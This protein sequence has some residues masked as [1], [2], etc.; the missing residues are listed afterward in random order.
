MLFLLAIVFPPLAFLTIGKPFQ[1]M[2]SAALMIT[3][4]GWLPAALW[5]GMVVLDHRAKLN[6]RAVLA[7]LGQEQAAS[8]WGDLSPIGWTMAIIALSLPFAAAGGLLFYFA[9]PF[10]EEQSPPAEVP[11]PT[12]PVVTQAP[13]M[14]K[15]AIADKRASEPK[16]TTLIHDPRK[17]AYAI[18]AAARLATVAEI[19]LRFPSSTQGGNTGNYMDRRREALQSLRAARYAEIA[20]RH[21]VPEADID[22]ILAE[23]DRVGWPVGMVKVR[24]P[25]PSEIVRPD[26][27]A[28]SSAKEPTDGAPRRLP[29]DT[30]ARSLLDMATNH[31]R[32]GRY[33]QAMA[34]YREVIVKYPGTVEA[35]EAEDASTKVPPASTVP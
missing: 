24:T 35:I 27:F 17:T 28:E 15:A 4:F 20:R 29:S 12:T 11:A 23:G 21:D 34:I 30:R 32:D 6:D 14:P 2:L 19:D 1:A 8:P 5:A 13:P 3:C 16:K 10:P 26:A 22:S 31:A 7:A 25:D 33:P 18:L 9:F